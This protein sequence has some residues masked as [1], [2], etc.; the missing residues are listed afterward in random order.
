MIQ[1]ITISGLHRDKGNNQLSGSVVI[2]MSRDAGAQMRA[3]F[4]C[5]VDGTSHTDD[6][7]LITLARDAL[8]QARRLPDCAD[9]VE[10]AAFDPQNI[11][12]VA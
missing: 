8:R 7:L 10:N 2:E 3:Q 6:Q 4:L 11:T 5:R 12:L 9:L 1:S